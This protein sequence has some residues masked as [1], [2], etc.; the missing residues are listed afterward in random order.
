MSYSLPDFEPKLIYILFE[1][2]YKE[3]PW[4]EEYLMSNLLPEAQR[5]LDTMKTEPE[6]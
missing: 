1:A 4:P 2:A 5:T 6:I 3:S